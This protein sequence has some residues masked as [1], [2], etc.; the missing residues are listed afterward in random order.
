M[1]SYSKLFEL[2]KEILAGFTILVISIITVACNTNFNEENV[3]KSQNVNK[4]LKIDKLTEMQ[5]ETLYK[6]GKIWGLLKYHHPEVA[7]GKIDCDEELFE[8]LPEVLKTKNRSESNEALYQ[9]VNSFGEVSIQDIDTSVRNVEIKLSPSTDWIKDEKLLGKKLS[10][11]LLKIQKAKGSE[12]NRYID[13]VKD[14]GNPIFTSEKSYP[15][16]NEKDDKYTLLALF[17]YWNMIEYYFPYKYLI[18]D[19]WDNVLQD[20]IPIMIECNDELT[21]NLAISQL[22]GKIQD[23]HGFI[24]TFDGVLSSFWGRNI[25]PIKVNFIENQLTV[26]DLINGYDKDINLKPGDII[27]KINGQDVEDIIKEKEKYYPKTSYNYYRMF[28]EYFPL[29]TNE[30]YM[31]L[32]IKRDENIIEEKVKCI[33]D[34][35]KV[36]FE[37]KSKKSHEFIGDSIG[38]IYPE[39]LKKDEIHG[40]MK[41]FKNTDGLIVDLRCYPS[42]FIVYSLGEYLMPK[43]TNFVKC[44]KANPNKPGEFYM[45][46]PVTVGK[47]NEGYYKGKVVILIN[48]ISRSQ[49]EFTAMALR[50]APNAV[51]VGSNS[52]GADGNASLIILPGNIKTCISGIGIYYPDGGETQRIGIIPDVEV[53]PTIKGIKEGK[54]EVLEKAVEI[55]ESR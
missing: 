14:V 21:Y 29:R 33:N 4:T 35:M 43:P 38:Y 42:D 23:G 50:V 8:I 2:K 47:N 7:K 25:V 55:I 52:F 12:K 28:F 51:V 27:I 22:I 24:N 5:K 45:G 6:L 26:V 3:D 19:N 17:R 20:F 13:F 54:D 41:K 18:D 37:Q 36:L 30:K 39:S 1:K 32:L 10:G 34:L 15:G 46:K 40:I 48:Y 53:K 49:P 44:S 31:N 11:I 16:M 9:W